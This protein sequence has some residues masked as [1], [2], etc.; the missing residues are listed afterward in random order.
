MRE[1]HAWNREKI[2]ENVCRIRQLEEQVEQLNEL[3]AKLTEVKVG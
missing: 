2:N 3:I 1:A